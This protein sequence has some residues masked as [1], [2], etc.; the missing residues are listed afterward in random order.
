MKTPVRYR[1]EGLYGEDWTTWDEL[2]QI[3]TENVQDPDIAQLVIKDFTQRKEPGVWPIG[4]K[5]EHRIPSIRRRA[6]QYRTTRRSTNIAAI[7]K[8]IFP[9]HMP[10]MGWMFPCFDWPIIPRTNG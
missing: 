5:P 1:L 10:I 9:S 2:R 8:I 7:P 4:P 6:S 3:V